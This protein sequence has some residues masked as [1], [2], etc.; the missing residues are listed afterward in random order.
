[1]PTT[2]TKT[3]A[4]HMRPQSLRTVWH[5]THGYLYDLYAKNAVDAG[6]IYAPDEPHLF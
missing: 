6:G 3:N 2:K 5:F 4:I 1:M